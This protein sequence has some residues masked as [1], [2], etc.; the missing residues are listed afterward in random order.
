VFDDGARI[1]LRLSGTGTE[2]ATLRLYLERHAADP[3]HH[4]IPVQTALAELA[5]VAE[6]VA[7]IRTRTGRDGPS[8]AT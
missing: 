1:V 5:A 8:V 4:D 6:D 3:A 7:G 2:G